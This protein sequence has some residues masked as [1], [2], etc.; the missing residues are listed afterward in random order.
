LAEC[1]VTETGAEN[2][3]IV[4]SG[5]RAPNPGELL[6]GERI[7]EM[8]EEA[9]ELYDIIILD[10][11]PMLPVPDTRMI[12]P[13]ADNICVVVRSN[14]APKGA[15]LRTLDLLDSYGTSPS[16]LVLNAH[17]ESRGSIG[18]NYSYG[19]YRMSKFG[20]PYQYGYGSYG[21]YGA[22]GADDD[23]EDD[24]SSKKSKRKR[25]K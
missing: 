13:Y 22:Y 7:R 17:A 12:A 6:D 20:K 14:Y 4:F 3:H 21:S 19:N 15:V 24:S 11:A 18:Q 8:I 5:V 16:G 10:T 2:L 25:S 23:D 1:I 9:K